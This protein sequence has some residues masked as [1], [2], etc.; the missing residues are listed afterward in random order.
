M[1]KTRKFP[2]LA[3]FLLC[4]SFSFGQN[5]ISGTVFNSRNKPVANAL[6][7]MDSINSGVTTDK[8]GFYK[9]QVPEN[10]KDINVYS[11]KYGL[12]SSTIPEEKVINFIYIDNKKTRKGK[13]VKKSKPVEIYFSDEENAY[14]VKKV[15]KVVPDELYPDIVSFRNIYDM[16]RGRVPGVYVT[17]DNR[18]RIRGVNSPNSTSD[19]LFIVDGTPVY[20]IGNILP[21]NV[22][23]IKVLKGAE[24]AIYGA[25]GAN[26]VILI[27]T[28]S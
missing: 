11:Y 24:T 15:D 19:P 3:I 4:F 8:K 22:K 17:S 26:G 18:V 21:I 25:R 23:D 14:V 20:S 27:T 1:L 9:V 16:I 5:E 13:R 7:Y 2:C 12:L 6:I 10:A 28:K